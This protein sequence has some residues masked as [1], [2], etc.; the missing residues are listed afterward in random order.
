MNSSFS[1]LHDSVEYVR[2]KKYQHV[3]VIEVKISSK[4]LGCSIGMNWISRSRLVCVHVYECNSSRIF[5]L[6]IVYGYRFYELLIDICSKLKSLNRKN[7][8]WANKLAQLVYLPLWAQFYFVQ[9]DIEREKNTATRTTRAGTQYT[10]FVL[11]IV[12]RIK[13]KE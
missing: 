5:R 7:K 11:E 1:P 10:A 9:F 13:I 6:T 8:I 2:G 4:F 3:F 12:I